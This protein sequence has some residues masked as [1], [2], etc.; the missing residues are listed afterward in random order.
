MVK[1]GAGKKEDD[2]KGVWVDEVR[3]VKEEK[4]AKWEEKGEGERR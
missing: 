1:R 2:E 3:M 4:G